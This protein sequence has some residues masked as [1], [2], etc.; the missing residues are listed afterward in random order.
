MLILAVIQSS[1]YF[2]TYG[3]QI[4]RTNFII[5]SELYSILKKN[6]LLTVYHLNPF[7]QFQQKHSIDHFPIL[8]FVQSE[9]LQCGQTKRS[10]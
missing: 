5:Y 7:A 4:S 1:P 8:H 9:N 3:Q 10:K 6:A 2:V